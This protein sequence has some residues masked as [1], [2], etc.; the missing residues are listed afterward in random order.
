MV[1]VLTDGLIALAIEEGR[2]GRPSTPSLVS[3]LPFFFSAVFTALDVVVIEV[4]VVLSL[5]DD[6]GFDTDCGFDASGCAPII[7][8]RNRFFLLGVPALEP[9]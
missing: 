5:T 8:S 4:E 2:A 6:D 1:S 9:G 7:M 3:R